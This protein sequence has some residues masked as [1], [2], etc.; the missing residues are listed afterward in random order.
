M[1]KEDVAM[2]ETEAA[3]KLRRFPMNTAWFRVYVGIALPLGFV[4][5]GYLLIDHTAWMLNP[6]NQE[7]RFWVIM[8][9]LGVLRM[10]FAFKAHRAAKS[11]AAASMQLL[12]LQLLLSCLC[13]GAYLAAALSLK[14]GAQFVLVMAGVSLLFF[15]GWALPNRLYFQRRRALFEPKSN[16]KED[17]CQS[18][19]SKLE[20]SAVRCKNCGSGRK[21]A[22]R[23]LGIAAACFLTAT[24]LLGALLGETRNSAMLRKNYEKA[25]QENAELKEAQQM[26][27]QRE[28]ERAISIDRLREAAKADEATIELLRKSYRELQQSMGVAQKPPVV[29]LGSEKQ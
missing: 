25:M 10:I 13:V 3:A 22:F 26:L 11:F 16:G 20:E 6:A 29:S 14:T 18:C 1:P 15:G 19:G 17:Y 21:E 23:R 2:F 4:L 28:L 27:G 12:S 8:V 5:F 9:V 7:R 24:L